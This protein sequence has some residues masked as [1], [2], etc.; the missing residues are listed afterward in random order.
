MQLLCEKNVCEILLNVCICVCETEISLERD[1]VSVVSA[2]LLWNQF[3]HSEKGLSL[4]L[5]MCMCVCATGTEGSFTT[6][7]KPSICQAK[8][9]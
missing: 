1:T 4:S 7:I 6:I 2:V 8:I 3:I 5:V 9:E